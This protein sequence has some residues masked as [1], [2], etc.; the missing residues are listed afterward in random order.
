MNADGSNRVQAVP[1][2][3]QLAGRLSRAYGC[4][5]WSPDGSV[6]AALRYDG[7]YTR[8]A[9]IS[10]EGGLLGIFPV[11]FSFSIGPPGMVAG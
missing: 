8:L 3:P 10:R 6:M 4:P 11:D 7:D 1:K 5:V 9:V 2:A